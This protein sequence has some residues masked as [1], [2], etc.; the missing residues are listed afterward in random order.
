MFGWLKAKEELVSI[1]SH[2]HLIHQKLEVFIDRTNDDISDKSI[3][4]EALK[5]EV[6]LH[7]ADLNQ[8][9]TVQEN[10]KKLLGM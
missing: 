7:V 9:A 3:K 1:L 8:A 6:G 4:I 10:I 2:F 5:T